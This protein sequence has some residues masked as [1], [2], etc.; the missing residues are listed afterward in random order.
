MGK[1]KLKYC[2]C[3]CESHV[4]KEW[5]LIEIVCPNCFLMTTK[6]R[7]KDRWKTFKIYEKIN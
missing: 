1:L 2:D 3:E 4:R 7:R 6:K 5:W